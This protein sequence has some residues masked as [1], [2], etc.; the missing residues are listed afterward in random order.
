MAGTYSGDHSLHMFSGNFL[1]QVNI[2]HGEG[3]VDAKD[4]A[5]QAAHS[6]IIL[7]TTLT[8]VSK[9]DS[10]HLISA[11]NSQAIAAVTWYSYLFLEEASVNK[12][13][14]PWPSWE[15]SLQINSLYLNC[16]K[17]LL[18]V[19]VFL[20]VIG[21]QSCH[22]FPSSKISAA[23]FQL[24]VY[25]VIWNFSSM[26]FGPRKFHGLLTYG[27]LST[28]T[29]GLENKIKQKKG[30]MPN[31]HLMTSIKLISV[32]ST[33]SVMIAT[34]TKSML[35]MSTTTMHS[36]TALAATLISSTWFITR[37][38]K[39][40][41]ILVVLCGV[42]LGSSLNL[43]RGIFSDLPYCQPMGWVLGWHPWAWSCEKAQGS[44]TT[45][46]WPRRCGQT[47]LERTASA[48]SALAFSFLLHIPV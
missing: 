25:V 18:E 35:S 39:C 36:S 37:D 26:E 1:G 47:G 14:K 46:T 40:N 44:A 5:L 33:T 20:L 41:G 6:C 23:T 38:I 3:L 15:M 17:L 28:S 29:I 32:A 45:Y 10:A 13:L 16:K 12:E 31:L 48:S 19:Q 8:A 34:S 24:L 9:H 7:I 42:G 4:A 11:T 21:S 43:R 30:G 2:C 22:Y 27:H